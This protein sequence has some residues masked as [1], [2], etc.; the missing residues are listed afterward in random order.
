VTTAPD[1]SGYSPLGG[2]TELA[3]L[4]VPDWV[5]ALA[6][7]RPVEPVW[8]NEDGGIT[9]RIGA[10]DSFL[11]VQRPGPDWTAAEEIPRL[12]WVGRFV[13]APRVLASGERGD[14]SWLLTGGVAGRSAVDRSHRARPDLTVPALGRGLRRFHDSVPV[15]S[16]PFSWS[17]ADRVA[18]FG[19]D[20]VF[21]DRPPALDA[22]A[23]HGDACNP[24]FLLGADGEVSGYVDLGGLG[25]ADRWADLAPALLSLGWNYG[26]GWEA[27]FLEAYGTA[28][29]PAK[30]AFYTAL[31]NGVGDV[32]D[33]R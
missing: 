21:L 23:C 8:R 9:Y 20:P 16:C 5:A 4:T 14:V 22:V 29:D 10:G 2:Q 30:R 1:Y 3:H 17:V 27:S 13:P 25:V 33:R 32:L 28:D 24:N 7:G 31:W 19:L 15:A 26:P 11:K 6:S 18:R 12:D